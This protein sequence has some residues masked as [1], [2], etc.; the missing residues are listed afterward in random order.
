MKHIIIGSGVIGRATGELLEAHN[1]SVTYHDINQKTIKKLKEAGKQ[2]T[3][4]ISEPYDIY[5]ICT[6]EWHIEN[7]LKKVNVK[8][9]HVVIRSTITPDTINNLQNEYPSFRFA[10]V[11]E[12]L[13]EKTAIQDI[14]NTERIIIGTTNLQIQDKLE[15]I[16]KD[17]NSPKII[18]K[19]EESS[20]IKLTAN[21][22]LAMQISFWNEMKILF[23]K[24]NVNPQLIS[25]AVTLDSR[26]SN[27][28]SN[29]LGKPFQ[30][31]CFPKD[32]ETLG[33]LFNKHD[34]NSQLIKSTITVN[35][36][37][38]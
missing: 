18:C 2:T 19:P 4:I 9:A 8:G 33:K 5:W 7:A 14:F 12:F 21:N 23:S 32:T 30:G 25:N 11:P 17:I 28:G 34:L 26:I 20:L 16:F 13:R 27:Y 35:K 38:E 22:W 37:I 10:H 6:A 31:F 15:Y 24:Y 1:H 29:M 3:L 36:V